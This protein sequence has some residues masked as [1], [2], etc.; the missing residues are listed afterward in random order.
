MFGIHIYRS[1]GKLRSAVDFT[2]YL[3]SVVRGLC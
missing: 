2:F 3:V 1:G